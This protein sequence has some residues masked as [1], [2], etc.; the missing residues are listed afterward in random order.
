M[1][2][3][4]KGTRKERTE[5]HKR[6]KTV[7]DEDEKN[8]VIPY[9]AGLTD[10][11]EKKLKTRGYNVCYQ[12]RGTLKNL[13]GR[14]KEKRPL[15]ES[16]GIYNIICKNC[17]SNYIGQTKRRIAIREEEHD[18]AHKLKQTEKS[19]FA[20]HCI[21]TGHKKSECKVLK[22]VDRA[23]DLDAWESLYMTRGRDLVNTA[24]PPIK[25]KLF[26]RTKPRS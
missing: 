6:D 17:P 23:R 14:K 20:A 22:V 7:T 18:R 21:Q 24:D 5:I 1:G 11:L 15:K 10:K 9:A 4:E 19:A 16:S 26:D 25:S 12:T 13:I 8:V 3:R 2:E